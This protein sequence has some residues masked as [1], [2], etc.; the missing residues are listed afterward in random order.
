[1]KSY[2]KHLE[3]TRTL[4]KA[5][6]S[7]RK[8]VFRSSA[9]FPVVQKKDFFTRICFLGYWVLKREIREVAFLYTLRNLKGEILK[10]DT[11]TIDTGK[12]FVI[13]LS[14]LL[15]KIDFHPDE[16][17]YGSVE[18]EIF[19]T[20]NLIYPYPAFVLSYYNEN[21]STSVHTASRIY[22]DVE[23]WRENDETSVPE[24]G[25]DIY[26]DDDLSPFIAFTNGPFAEAGPKI[27]YK[28]I[29]H[30]GRIFEGKIKLKPLAPFET[31]FLFLKDV[32]PNLPSMLE[33]K[34]GAIKVTHAFKGFFPR[35]L[36]GNFQDRP[37]TASITHTY[38]DCTSLRRESDYWKTK[39]E[40]FHSGSIFVP[41]FIE[42]DFF[43]EVIFYPI[44]SPSV[45]TVSVS[46]Y[47]EKGNLLQ[48]IPNLVRINAL[49][50][51]FE[52][53]NLK[54]LAIQHRVDLQ[55]AK[56]AYLVQ[57]SI[58][59]HPYPIRVKMGL[60][61]GQS[62]RPVRLPCNICFNAQ[63]GDPATT[64]KPRTFRWAPILNVGSSVVVWT[65]GSPL[66]NYTRSAHA[67]LQ[68][69]RETDDKHIDR[70]I[71]IPPFGQIYIEVEKDTELK[72]FLNQKTGWV[73]ALSDNPYLNGWY[74]D[75]HKNGAVAGDHCF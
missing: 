47:D 55:K 9:I 57:E 60:N 28:I 30:K 29:N 53:I 64:Q 18:L 10:R 46:F 8:P 70:Q 58:K 38:Y 16:T 73:T 21:F 12:A 33:G 39:D 63:V 34:P 74:F 75:F 19:S 7:D 15:G 42:K 24:S 23:D 69:F 11:W 67:Q 6:S 52:R 45:F 51:V 26:G 71:E 40:R 44:Y 61:V 22:N 72:R 50:D 68:F 37:T 62:A 25:F 54:T 13:E 41:L 20:Q 17:F 4:E 31:S 14:S 1:M 5:P 35:F 48:K 36:V 56:G 65:N 59:G 2:H 43:T 27:D 66:K 49:R 32:I 3:T